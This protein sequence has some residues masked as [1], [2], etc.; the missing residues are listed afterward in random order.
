MMSAVL[1]VLHVPAPSID[2]VSLVSLMARRVKAR[3]EF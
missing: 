2:G 1:D 3:I